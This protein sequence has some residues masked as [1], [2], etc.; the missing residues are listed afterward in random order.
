[1]A[2]ATTH[3]SPQFPAAANSMP[4]S[5]RETLDAAL[6]DL[7]AHADAWL[8]VTVPERIAIVDALMRDL[9][10]ASPRWVEACLR[11]KGLNVDLAGE[12]WAIGPYTVMK[13]LRQTRGALEDIRRG[14]APRI[15]GP[16]TVRPN[17]QVVARVFPQTRYDALLFT[18][19]TGEVWMQP[20]VTREGLAATQA[21]AY[22]D[23]RQT[24]QVALVLGAG[25]VS[26]IGPLDILYKLF[27]EDQVVVFKSNPVND[28]LGPVFA[29]ALR[30]LIAPGYLR[31]VYGGVAEGSYLCEHPDVDE[32]H[33]TGSD[34]TYDAIVWGTGDEGEARKMADTPLLDKRVSGELGNV[35]PVIVVP[36]PWSGRDIAYQA[37]H[38]A[39]SLVTNAGFNCNASRVIVTHAGWHDRDAL[40]DALRR[41]LAAVPPRV[42]YYPGAEAREQR[43][44]EAHPAAEQLGGAGGHGASATRPWML[45]PGVNPEN[46]DD[47]CFTTEAFCGLF[48][49]SP[50]AAADAA[51][52]LDRA[53]TFCN[54]RLWGSLNATILVHP[55]SLKEPAVAAALERAQANLRYGTV[56][57][58]YWA[59]TAFTMGVLPWGAYPGHTA[60][61]IQSGSGVVHNTLMFSQPQKS[62]LRG[63]WRSTPTPP[64]FASQ[65]KQAR[66]VFPRLTALE[67]APSPSKLPGILRAAIAG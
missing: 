65:R 3:G 7:R 23:K 17:G 2:I 22:R 57:I 39:S 26:S 61:D 21:I 55:R 9:W 66:A 64:W 35:S 37:Q 67:L 52:F 4:P 38:L 13:A 44:R 48:A 51:Q 41:T 46:A 15:P 47:I 45:I 58:N 36:G 24:G 40:L 34:K 56:G 32:I 18:G 27:V 33:I 11:A 16:V 20:G 53:V 54:E 43:F 29:D 59:G 25:N 42:A 31:L 14:A 5:D 12:E 19:V 62:V 28:Y 63:P 50:L 8:G 49:E 30:A 1:M 6:R 10:A 60:K